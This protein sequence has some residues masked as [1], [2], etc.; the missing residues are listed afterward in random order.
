MRSLFLVLLY[1][2]TLS[3]YQLTTVGPRGETPVSTHFITLRTEESATAHK[4]QFT[5]AIAFHD[6][7]SYFSRDVI[8]SISDHCR[9]LN[10]NI[11]FLESANFSVST[12]KEHYQTLQTLQPDLLITL[13]LSPTETTEELKSLA[14][15]GT[16][17]AFL[18]NLPEQLIHRQHYA[19]VVTDDLFEMGHVMANQIAK[20]SGK[21]ARILYIYHGAEY[22]VT[23]Q[24]DQSMRNVIQLAYPEMT[25]VDSIPVHS[26][27]SI[28]D[29]VT[30]YLEKNDN[31][32]NAIY[33][34]WATIAEQILPIVSTNTNLIDLYTIDKSRDVCY[35]LLF[36]HS[37]KG[38][39]VDDPDELG[40]ALLTS[41]IL[42]KL[43]KLTPTFASVTVNAI[44][45]AASN[46]CRS[47]FREEK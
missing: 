35:D 38:I 29:E 33:T 34:P 20:Y 18:S 8:E 14:E 3:A 4:E 32:I 42:H 30:R 25:I 1:T 23:N 24:R 16:S 41:A 17:I 22:Y 31:D 13:T 12:Q 27:D 40:R 45:D 5:L 46:E 7:S 44:N 2:L 11:V 26:P 6:T 28:K 10:I 47:Y 19:S 37:V 43:G 21:D 39:V 15:S 9:Q 36:R